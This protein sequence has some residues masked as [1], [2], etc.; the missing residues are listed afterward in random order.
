MDAARRHGPPELRVLLSPELSERL[1]RGSAD[2]RSSSFPLV[3][4]AVARTLA[5]AMQQRRRR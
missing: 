1:V 3:S 4:S 2:E 5:K